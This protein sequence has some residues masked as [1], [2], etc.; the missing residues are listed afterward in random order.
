MAKDVIITPA[1]GDIQF[2]N[3][4][5]TDAGKIVQSGDDL[6]ISNAVGDVLLGDGTADVYIG[7]GSANVDIVFEQNGSI[8][9]ETGGTVALTLGSSD[10][11]LKLG[12]DLDVNGKSIVSA[13]N[14]DITIVPNGTGNVGIGTTTPNYLLDVENSGASA[15]I[16][17]TAGS[18]Q[19]YL[20]AYANNN[21][22]VNFGDA[23]DPDVGAIIYRHASD[24]LA[25]NV[26]AAERI[27]IDSSGNVGIGTASPSAKLDVVGDVEVNGQ[28]TINDEFNPYTLPAADGTSG[29]VLQTNGSGT[30]SFASI[31]QATGNELENLVEDTTPQLGG[32][33]D[34]N[35]NTIDMGTNV[36]TDTK[37]GQWDTAYGWGNH[38]SEGYLTSETSHA[39]VVVD[40]DFTSNGLM[41]RTGVGT[42]GIVT[43]N[44]SNWNTAYGWGN[45]AS[46]GYISNLVEDTT[47]QLGGT[48]DANG[49]TIDMGTNVITDTKVGHWDTAYG[50]GDH[51]TQGYFAKGSDIPSGADLNTYTTDGY[52]HQ[53]S[54]AN[55]AAGSNYPE[56]KAGMLVVYSDGVM[57]YQRYL[58]Y[59][60]T[61]NRYERGYYNGTWNSWKKLWH[62]SDFSS[63][64]I[65]NWDTAYGWGDHSAQS[66]LTDITTQRLDQLSDVYSSMSPTD[67]QV[68]TYDTTNGWQAE[69]PS[70]GVTASGTPV[71]YQVA[72]FDSSS[73]I[74]GDS[75]LTWT[76][77]QFTIGGG[78]ILSADLIKMNGRAPT[79][80]SAGEVGA[81]GN[82]ITQFHTSGSVTA[83]GVYVAGSSAWVQADA[84]AG[85]TA[86]GLLAVATDAASA[87]EMLIEG[88]VKL[89]S[90]TGFST[91]SKGDVLYLSLTAGELTNDI[92]SHTTGDFV[93]V[94]GYVI[95]ASKNYVYFSP[96]KDW[97]EL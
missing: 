80:P 75:N 83:G 1:N 94:C 47:P 36:I 85:S 92:S 53:N 79:S 35:G 39:D 96:S 5:G 89:A 37:V 44:S 63:T 18:T 7:D 91:A 20:Q 46:A 34:A 10:T 19:L 13:S 68:L 49:N 26:N 15:R 52:Y 90:N 4:S 22:V 59:D 76:G 42:Y 14:G 69:T 78:A 88:S 29:Q 12:S 60:S 23:L 33:L 70:G 50:W 45:H 38:A 61:T 28:I 6:V 2:S 95:D 51:S 87:A 9:G 81:G 40:G 56:D 55:A 16:Y 74:E 62:D 41:K 32:T 65:S 71:T 3:A 54:N 24:S 86:T 82:V 93:R 21:S 58:I 84:D 48:L 43:D 77:T 17:N 25:F 73:S 57:V 27:R 64:D 97:I 66:Y 11:T 72:V 30:L 8:R 31:T 67:G